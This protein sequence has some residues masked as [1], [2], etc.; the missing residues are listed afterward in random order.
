MSPH[1]EEAVPIV[2]S[3]QILAIPSQT[4]SPVAWV[5]ASTRLMSIRPPASY[6]DIQSPLLAPMLEVSPKTYW[7]A[8]CTKRELLAEHACTHSHIIMATVP[9]WN[10]N[11]PACTPTNSCAVD[12]AVGRFGFW[13]SLSPVRKLL[14]AAVPR[15]SPREASATFMLRRI[16]RSPRVSG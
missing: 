9:S 7:A 16:C 12:A 11:C 6:T 13:E 10:A 4:E 1:M 3:S 14:H 2:R 15:S 5:P 8:C